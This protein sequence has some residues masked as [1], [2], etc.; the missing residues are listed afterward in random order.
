MVV[1]R[2]TNSFVCFR[3][4]GR[5][6]YRSRQIPLASIFGIKVQLGIS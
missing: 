6:V 4:D 2:S 5:R 1:I 3:N